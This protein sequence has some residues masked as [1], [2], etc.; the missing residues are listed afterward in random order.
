MLAQDKLRA[1]EEMMERGDKI[2][3]IK[4]V[5]SYGKA[6][7]AT[8]ADDFLGDDPHRVSLREAK[9]AVEHKFSGH[10]NSAHHPPAAVLVCMYIVKS[11]QIQIPGEGIVELDMD[12]LQMKFLQELDSVG[13]DEVQHLLELTE[14]IKKWQSG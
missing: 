5:R 14:F 2:P 1:V 4:T 12:N 6:F 7:P 9:H 8:T 11:L 10:F 13:L 3:A